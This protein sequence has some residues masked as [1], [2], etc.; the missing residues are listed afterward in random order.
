MVGGS[1][2][3]FFQLRSLVATKAQ[4]VV[5]AVCLRMGTGRVTVARAEVL[6]VVVMV[7]LGGKG[8]ALPSP[9]SG[10]EMC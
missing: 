9:L 4:Q 3:E 8:P 6:L 7:V 5:E 1:E 10:E 2:R